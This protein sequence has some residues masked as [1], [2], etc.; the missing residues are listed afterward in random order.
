[1]YSL[2]FLFFIIVIYYTGKLEEQKL[3]DL[4]RSEFSAVII[5]KFRLRE[6]YLRCVNL[7]SKDTFKV[8]P[9]YELLDRSEL[10]DTFHKLPQSNLIILRNDTL[11]YSGHDF[12]NFKK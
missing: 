10:M 9:S 2:F 8:L 6:M 3:S 5:E 4:Y 11:I 1:M 7:E 12:S